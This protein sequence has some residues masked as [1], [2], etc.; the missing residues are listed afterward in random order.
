MDTSADSK[1]TTRSALSEGTSMQAGDAAH[2]HIWIRW[3]RIWH[4]AFHTLLVLATLFALSDGPRSWGRRAAMVALALALGG[5][6]WSMVIRRPDRIRRP[7]PVLVYLGGAVSLYMALNYLHPAFWLLTFVLYLQI[8]SF[9]PL[10]WAIPSALVLNCLLFWRNLDGRPFSESGPFLLIFICSAAFGTLLALFIDAIIRQSHERQRLIENL[11]ATRHELA[12]EERRAGVLEERQRIAREIHDTLA[13]GFTG[14]VMHL[15]A[16]EAAMP[17][18]APEA[19]HHLDQARRTAR[20]SLAEA[21]RA[22]WALRPEALERASLP[23]TLARLAERWTQENGI[24]ADVT[25]TGAPR[26]LPPEVEVT[27]LRSA[28]ESLANVRRHA[29]ASRVA[30]TLSYM[31]EL[32]TL[33][34]RDDGLGFEPALVQA[35]TGDG[36]T[37]RFGLQAMRE[38]VEALEGD[39]T[40]ESEPGGGTTLTVQLPTAACAG[41]EL[42]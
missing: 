31:D 33:D 37:G 28:Q 34:V 36:A 9:L 14:V 23:D 1:R 11:E 6:Y 7:L 20:E 32:T 40:V 42:V 19:Q 5:W 17:P 21:R 10:R 15:E 27:L 38:R 16:A 3:V 26:K 35:R 25:V 2:T 24:R 13:Q 8:F 39:L 22:I 41:K 30:L 4:A 18:G 12:L 29:G